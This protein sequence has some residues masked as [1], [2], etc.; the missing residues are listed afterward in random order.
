[1]KRCESAKQRGRRLRLFALKPSQNK[2]AN[3][4]CLRLA[5]KLLQR[6]P[7]LWPNAR[8]KSLQPSAPRRRPSRASQAEQLRARRPLAKPKRARPPQSSAAKLWAQASAAATFTRP[9]FYK[10]A[11]GESTKRRGQRVPQ[12]KALSPNRRSCAFKRGTCLQLLALKLLQPWPQL[13]PNARSKSLQAS[14]PRWPLR[15]SQA[16][17]LRARRP[18]A[19]P[20]RAR[21]PQSRAVKLWAQASAAATFTRQTLLR[22]NLLQRQRFQRWRL[23]R[24]SLHLNYPPPLARGEVVAASRRLLA[25]L[26]KPQAAALQAPASPY[27]AARIGQ[28]TWPA[29]RL[30]ALKPSQNKDANFKRLHCGLVVYARSSASLITRPAGVQVKTLNPKRFVSGWYWGGLKQPPRRAAP[31]PSGLRRAASE[32]KP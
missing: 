29:L 22:L 26:R 25:G 20:K 4:K 5:L 30:F 10:G 6:W 27:E 3:F 1:M 7:Q 24:C 19:K 23:N 28:A 32:G 16:K 9:P 14:A 12:S 31:R 21:P 15:A 8:S 17:Q 13:W 18:V 11:R 2:D